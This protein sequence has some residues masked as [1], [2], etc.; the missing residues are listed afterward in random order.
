MN[1]PLLDII[2]THYNEPWEVGKT[3]FE[4]LDNQKCVDF[5]E[6]RVIYVQDGAEGSPEK[7]GWSFR[8][9]PYTV[10]VVTIPEH[11]GTERARNK[12]IEAATADWVMFCD[13]DDTFTSVNSLSMIL[14]QFP[15]RDYDIIWSRTLREMSWNMETTY[16]NKQDEA[17]FAFTDGKLYRREFLN[18]HH[19]RFDRRCGRFSQHIFNV[20]AME[21]TE[22][23]RIAMLTTDFHVY[24]KTRRAGS[25]TD[26]IEC[27]AQELANDRLI[28]DLII[29]GEMKG[30]GHDHA[31]R[32]AV[33]KT[34]C[35]VYKA[36]REPDG[37]GTPK[38]TR[39]FVDFYR[40]KAH[41]LREMATSDVDVL[42]DEAETESMNEIQRQF[43]EG[44]RELYLANDETSFEVWVHTM[45]GLSGVEPVAR[46]ERKPEPE[47]EP[48][49]STDELPEP[50][51][52]RQEKQDERVVVYCGTYNTYTNMIASAK[53]LLYNTKVDK[54]Y[55]LTEDDTFPY[56]LPDKIENINVKPLALRTFRE[57]GPNFKNSWTYMCMARA[58]FPQMFPQHRKALSLD[59]DVVVQEDIGCLWD[60]DMT[61]CYL[62]GVSEP[63]RQ[64]SSADPLYINFGV[65]MMDLEKLRRGG[66]DQTIID[67]LNNVKYGCPE[68]DAF[69]KACAGHIRQ[70]PNDYNFTPYSHITGEAAQ[71]RIVHYAGLKFWRHY[72]SVRQYS[73][74]NWDDVMKRQNSLTRTGTEVTGDTDEEVVLPTEHPHP[75][76]LTKISYP[77]GVTQP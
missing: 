55:F 25:R 40:D 50:E 52:E 63:S 13:F 9:R 75:L 49:P 59:I 16:L 66:L 7:R 69:N 33:V 21:E 60:T 41:I 74:L 65:V 72:S 26:R 27:G 29:C 61:D 48:E 18:E 54:V 45:D 39:E 3:L 15:Q 47:N 6:F 19:I 30:R 53:S 43:N 4:V 57:D 32:K 38:I 56:P 22:P 34:I 20:V 14:S 10:K 46:T 51:P 68:Q 42:L 58:L 35:D 8:G 62:A 11:V 71:E 67:N 37:G 23:W 28:R 1:E 12:G 31:Y 36:V 17:N 44:H 2:V 76:K 5:D 73:D 70:I 24:M 77:T 64:N